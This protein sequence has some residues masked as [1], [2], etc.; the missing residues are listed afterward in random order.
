MTKFPKFTCGALWARRMWACRSGISGARDGRT[1]PS[2]NHAITMT[3]I[4][5]K[6]ENVCCMRCLK[7]LL[8]YLMAGN[9]Y[10]MKRMHQKYLCLL[11]SLTALVYGCNS[12]M[13]FFLFLIYYINLPTYYSSLE[14]FYFIAYGLKTSAHN[15]TFMIISLCND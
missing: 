9:S 12:L 14:P 10:E 13:F 3:V 6:W 2:V 4:N 5:I 11:P 1:P 8:I 15:Q 7:C